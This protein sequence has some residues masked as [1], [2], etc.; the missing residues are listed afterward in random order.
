[1]PTAQAYSEDAIQQQSTILQKRRT[2]VDHRDRRECVYN[3]SDTETTV[4]HQLWHFNV[5]N[6]DYV[7]SVSSKADS[8]SHS[9]YTNTLNKWCAVRKLV[10]L[11]Y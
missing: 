8:F 11:I 1:M 5:R 4:S 9:S 7:K 3:H 2:S 10:F 6:R